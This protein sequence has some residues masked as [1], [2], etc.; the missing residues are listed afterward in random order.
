MS[1]DTKRKEYDTFGQTSE[2]MGRQGNGPSPGAHHHG[3]NQ[4]WQFRSTVDPEELFRKIFGD[5]NFRNDFNDFA[6]SQFGFGGAQE[7]TMNLTFAQAARG[8]NKDVQLNIVDTCPK[9]S[10]S[11]CELGTKPIKCQ[12]CHGSG[13][14]TIS[15]GPFV[16]RSTCRYCSGTGQYIKF[17]CVECE[18]KGQ[19]VSIFLIA[20][21]WGRL[22]KKLKA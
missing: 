2:Q 3:F 21:T 18:G 7:I 14:E 22:C 16:M 20:R 11:R 4:N 6:E 12:F 1:D 15:T 5:A 8:V 19:S 13:M 10:G 17:Q 9:C